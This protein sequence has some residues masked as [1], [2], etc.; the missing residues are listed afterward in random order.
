MHPETLPDSDSGDVDSRGLKRPQMPLH[1]VKFN[2]GTDRYG[3]ERK[4]E[5]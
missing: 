5:R 4:I 2:Y 3:I 1:T